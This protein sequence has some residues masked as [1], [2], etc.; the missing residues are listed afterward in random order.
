VSRQGRTVHIPTLQVLF[1][2][3]ITTGLFRITVLSMNQRHSERV[4]LNEDSGEKEEGE[5]PQGPI[6]LFCR[7]RQLAWLGSIY[8]L[9]D[10]M[11]LSY[12]VLNPSES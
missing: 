2:Q 12:L 10:G 1:D 4:R 8:L 3:W 11:F 7:H 9:S 5:D 6:T